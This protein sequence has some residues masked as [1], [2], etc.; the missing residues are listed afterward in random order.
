MWR[1]ACQPRKTLKTLNRSVAVSVWVEGLKG[2][3]DGSG[4]Y[5][6]VAMGVPCAWRSPPLE[7][8]NATRRERSIQRSLARSAV[9]EDGVSSGGRRRLKRGRRQN[10]RWIASDQRVDSTVRHARKKT[11]LG[12]P[13]ETHT[14]GR[15]GILPRLPGTCGVNVIH[16]T[17]V[18]HSLILTRLEAASPMLYANECTRKPL[19]FHLSRRISPS[20]K[21]RLPV[22]T[23]RLGDKNNNHP[24]T[25]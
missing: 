3:T 22:R 2:G 9:V 23:T 10:H 14:T 19:S 7:L 17:R 15:R 13:L 4:A 6:A 1:L 24:S 11:L 25:L 16:L 20:P 5:G 21:A 18:I 12:A 8:R